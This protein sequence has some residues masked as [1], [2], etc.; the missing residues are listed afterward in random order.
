MRHGIRAPFGV[1]SKK[2]APYFVGD[3]ERDPHLENYPYG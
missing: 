1:L 3:L 2:R